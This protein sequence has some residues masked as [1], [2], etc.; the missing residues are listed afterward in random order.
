MPGAGPRGDYDDCYE[1]RQAKGRGHGLVPWF[2]TLGA[3]SKQ[4]TLAA[5][6]NYHGASPW[7]VTT[8]AISVGANLILH[9]TSRWYRFETQL[10]LHLLIYHLR[11][12][13]TAQIA[14]LQ[15]PRR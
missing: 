13:L 7:H 4:P 2:F 8:S 5:I 3:L 9:R 11:S 12:H 14:K 10:L 6:V 15:R 1:E